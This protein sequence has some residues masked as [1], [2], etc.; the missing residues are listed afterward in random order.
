MIISEG[1]FSKR[2]Q[3]GNSTSEKTPIWRGIFLWKWPWVWGFSRHPLAQ[4]EYRSVKL[5][6]MGNYQKTQPTNFQLTQRKSR[7][8][9]LWAQAGSAPLG[10]SGK[11]GNKVRF[12]SKRLT[13][14]VFVGLEF[15]KMS[16]FPTPRFWLAAQLAVLNRDRLDKDLGNYGKLSFN[17]SFTQSFPLCRS[18]GVRADLQE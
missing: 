10:V 16:M 2:T 3:Q 7:K 12:T 17:K 15:L 11:P 14:R 5:S 1:S 8:Q 13:A 6:T 4:K 18:V 9:K